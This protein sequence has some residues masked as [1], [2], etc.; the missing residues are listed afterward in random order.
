MDVQ[1]CGMEIIMK[2]KL[3]NQMHADSQEQLASN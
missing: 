1:G 3:E 2:Q